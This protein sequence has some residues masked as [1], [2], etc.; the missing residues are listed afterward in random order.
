MNSNVYLQFQD[1]QI[2]ADYNKKR[3]PEIIRFNIILV[4]QRLIFFVIMLGS[5]ATLS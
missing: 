5:Y 2:L 1:A 3:Y 4:V